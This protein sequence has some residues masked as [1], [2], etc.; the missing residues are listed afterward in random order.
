[1]DKDYKVA[2][3]SDAELNRISELEQ[4]INQENN[5]NIVLVAYEKTK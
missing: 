5:S 1:M 2:Q 3:I 4:K